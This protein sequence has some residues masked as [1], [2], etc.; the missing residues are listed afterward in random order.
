[1]M[2]PVGIY[3]N[4]YVLLT[5]APRA[6]RP[7]P[8]RELAE[9]AG[10]KEKALTDQAAHELDLC[11]ESRY[12]LPFRESQEEVLMVEYERLVR[13]RAPAWDAILW[14]ALCLPPALI[15]DT[16]LLPEYCVLGA[17]TLLLLGMD[18]PIQ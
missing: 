6:P 13:E 12:L 8:I 18:S 3:G 2:F 10:I 1:M 11:E 4:M 5:V 14:K 9:K 16:L 15:A 7:N 17:G